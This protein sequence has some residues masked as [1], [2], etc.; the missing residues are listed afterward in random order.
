MN[1][2]SRLHNHL[3]VLDAKRSRYRYNHPPSIESTD[4]VPVTVVYDSG[5]ARESKTLKLPDEPLKTD[6][7][8]V[9][10]TKKENIKETQDPAQEP[11]SEVVTPT[12]RG[13]KKNAERKPLVSRVNSKK[14][15][16]I[17]VNVVYETDANGQR[18]Q[19]ESEEK[20]NNIIQRRKQIR[21]RLQK[22]EADENNQKTEQSNGNTLKLN[23]ENKT[24]TVSSI[25]TSTA[26]IAPATTTKYQPQ[27][28][29]ERSHKRTRTRG[30]TIPIVTEEN[31]VYSHSGNFHYR[32]EGGDGTK[33]FEEGKL[34]TINNETG[35]VVQG[36]FSY[37]DKEGKDYSIS[38]TADENGY[39]PTGAHLPT[40]PPIPPEI[41]RALAY[42]ATKTTPQPV[43]EPIRNFD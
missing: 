41:A 39:R 43:T 36:G 15:L 14:N 42:L 18:S 6:A 26:E 8:E 1:E 28:T 21:R 37:T 38:Y 33:V 27:V 23:E 30:P 22:L 9:S 35:E 12:Q 17:P 16:Q 32:F 13:V 19:Q 4:T 2:C 5:D 10:I 31:F 7:I 29:T 20:S 11:K 24:T 34:K 3:Y 25:S 40:P